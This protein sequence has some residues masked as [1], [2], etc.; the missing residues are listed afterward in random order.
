MFLTD[1]RVQ[2]EG[3][4]LSSRPKEKVDRGYI[5]KLQNA[6]LLIINLS[7]VILGFQTQHSPIHKFR[8]VQI[9]SLGL[10]QEKGSE[11]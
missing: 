10:T 1:P 4:R 3:Q 5:K 2:H 7:A 8:C 9:Y 11:V 6:T